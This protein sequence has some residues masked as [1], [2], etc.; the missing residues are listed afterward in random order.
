MNDES[1]L[2][3]AIVAG[4]SGETFNTI[5]SGARRRPL[6]F[7]RYIVA[8]ELYRRGYSTAKAGAQVGLDHAT[9]L[10]GMRQLK[11]M[12][13]GGYNGEMEIQRDF[14]RILDSMDNTEIEP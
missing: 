10:H 13:S 8:R 9:V 5:L 11:L 6:P 1:R 3:V 14:N 2:L 4:V 12:Y 7:C